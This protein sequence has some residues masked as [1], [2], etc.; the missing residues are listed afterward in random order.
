MRTTGKT[1]ALA[2]RIAAFVVRP[3]RTP[4]LWKYVSRLNPPATIP[5]TSIDPFIRCRTRCAR[6][7][8]PPPSSSSPSRTPPAVPAISR[9]S[10]VWTAT[11]TDSHIWVVAKPSWNVRLYAA[12]A[13]VPR[14]AFFSFHIYYT[15]WQGKGT[16]RRRD[17]WEGAKDVEV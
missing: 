8:D 5:P 11:A 15:S 9:A 16:R 7:T 12:A 17:G 13:T 14:S 6:R 4:S 10:R 2:S 1:A 3:R